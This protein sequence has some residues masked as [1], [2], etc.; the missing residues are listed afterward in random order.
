MAISSRRLD[1]NKS[2]CRHWRFHG[3][4]PH[5]VDQAT[6]VALPRNGM[7]KVAPESLPLLPPTSSERDAPG[8]NAA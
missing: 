3:I 6:H 1:R 8:V 2:R 4:P 7:L 5:A